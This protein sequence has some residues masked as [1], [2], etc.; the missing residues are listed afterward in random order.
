MRFSATSLLLVGAL[1]SGSQLFAQTPLLASSLY[2]PNPADFEMAAEDTPPA[3]AGAVVPA[4]VPPTPD[5]S[6]TGTPELSSSTQQYRL[7]I[8][9]LSRNKRQFVRCKLNNNKV[10]TGL[11]RDVHKDGFSLETDAFGEAFVRYDSLVEAPRP[12][13]AVGTRI[14]QGAQWTGLVVFVVVFFIPLALTGVIPDC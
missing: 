11:P 14:K 5:A 7:A 4:P 10:L 8:E 13:A 9:T 6:Q 3:F 1:F 12:V 2:D